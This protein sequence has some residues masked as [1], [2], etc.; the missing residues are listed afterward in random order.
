MG[1]TGTTGK[2][3]DLEAKTCRLLLLHL[4]RYAGLDASLLHLTCVTRLGSRQPVTG[5]TPSTI[6]CPVQI[7]PLALVLG[8]T[9]T[10]GDVLAD[11]S[12]RHRA[13][14]IVEYVPRA[15]ADLQYT[16]VACTTGECLR[17]TEA[18]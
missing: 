3:A 2:T 17:K 13:A 5:C 15:S 4:D 9:H 11:D 7:A 6:R 14:G 10:L 8:K 12:N 18:A 1:V 16:W